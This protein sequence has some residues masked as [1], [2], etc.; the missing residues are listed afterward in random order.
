MCG[1]RENG[2]CEGEEAKWPRSDPLELQRGPLATAPT[3]EFLHRITKELAKGKAHR[4]VPPWSIPRE[5]WL[6]MLRP[7]DPDIV[8][9]M[10][11]ANSDD[12]F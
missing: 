12:I 6:T 10:T 5:I 9:T 4:A 2:G 3:N 7:R 8:E 11:E 1:P